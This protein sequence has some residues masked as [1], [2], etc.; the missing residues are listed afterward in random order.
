MKQITSLA[1]FIIT[2]LLCTTSCNES[3][4]AIVQAKTD[5][6][7]HPVSI[8]SKLELDVAQKYIKNYGNYCRR[9][10]QADA[11]RSFRIGYLDLVN[12]LGLPDSVAATAK[13]HDIRAYIAIE[14]EQQ[15]SNFHLLLTPVNS[16]GKDSILADVTGNRFVYDLI[17]PCPK[18]CDETSLLY[19]AFDS[20]GKK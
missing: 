4:T 11:L 15:S 13:F 16:M 14:G 5:S 2:M 18:T 12:V 7:D 10:G 19:R 9:T 8:V 3:A 20:T 17:T 1:A 6:N